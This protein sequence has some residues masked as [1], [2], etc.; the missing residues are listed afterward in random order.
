MRSIE[1]PTRRS[2]QSLT[3]SPLG[4]VKVQPS[5]SGRV[6]TM[7][8]VGTALLTPFATAPLLNDGRL[9]AV[10]TVSAFVIAILVPIHLRR[11]APQVA[12]MDANGFLLLDCGGR[13][14]NGAAWSE[15]TGVGIFDIDADQGQD[16]VIRCLDGDIYLHPETLGG[17]QL[18]AEASRRKSPEVCG[19]LLPTPRGAVQSETYYAR[20]CQPRWRRPVEFAVTVGAT[21]FLGGGAVRSLGTLLGQ[22]LGITPSTMQY[23]PVTQFFFLLIA[24]FGVTAS[25]L[26]PWLAWKEMVCDLERFDVDPSGI[27]WVC[28][29]QEDVTILWRDVVALYQLA[30]GDLLIVGREGEIVVP[31]SSPRFLEIL[32]AVT[33]AMPATARIGPALNANMNEASFD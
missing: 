17:V 5:L 4:S 13:V 32:G 1:A 24:V 10:V 6:G 9:L 14:Q 7:L 15:V 25:L 21:L 22:I 30:V 3:D 18:I 2:I 19:A 27:T 29:G 16:D 26:P 31:L 23:L 12:V 8:L 20:E 33:Q 28:H 11:S